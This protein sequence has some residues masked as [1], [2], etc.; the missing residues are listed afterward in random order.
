MKL[1]GILSA[2]T[3]FGLL[4]WGVH[5]AAV[6]V[7]PYES[8]SFS[9][10]QGEVFTVTLIGM[11]QG[12][13]GSLELYSGDQDLIVSLPFLE[14][15]GKAVVE[16]DG[17]DLADEIV[18][19]EAY[20]PVIRFIEGNINEVVDYR[21]SSGGE[22]LYD[23][24]K[25]IAEGQI[26]YSLPA[27]SRVLIRAGIKQGPMLRS[28]VDWY[29]RTAGFHAE[30]WNGYDQDNVMDIA[31]DKGIGYLIAAYK[32]PTYSIIT[33]GNTQENYRKYRERKGWELPKM[34]LGNVRLERDGNRLSREY[35]Q[36]LLQQRSPRITV[37]MTTPNGENE[38]TKLDS[39]EEAVIHV[40]L[41]PD[42][43]QYLIQSRYE[44]SFFVDNQFL[45]EEEQGYVPLRWKWSPSRFGLKPGKHVLTVNISGYE[46]QVGV[47]NL[48]FEINQD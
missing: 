38:V 43:E 26:E 2:F 23:F 27:D 42:D 22:E 10:A 4:L 33:F 44:V 11:K 48:A 24:D 17:R 25:R 6:E 40:S 37:S 19:D 16:W 31:H 15:D 46:G 29:P 41:H 13:S 8:S 7:V 18:P 20:A 30:R 45:A 5:A 3:C 1:K 47:K 35:F 14:N 21:H 32:L 39:L 28:I 36:P 9:P 12:T 34:P